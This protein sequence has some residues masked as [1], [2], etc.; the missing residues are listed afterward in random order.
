M[1]A[2]RTKRFPRKRDETYFCDKAHLAVDEGAAWRVR[3][4]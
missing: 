3:R 2:I 4:K 1:S